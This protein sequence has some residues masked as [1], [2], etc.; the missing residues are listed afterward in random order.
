MFDLHDGQNLE[1]VVLGKILER[2]AMMKLTAML[3]HARNPGLE[4]WLQGPAVR[5]G[6]VLTVQK[7]FTNKLKMLNKTTNM[8][9]LNF[10]LNPTTTITQATKPIKLTMTLQ[11]LQDPVNTKP[12]KRNTRRTRPPS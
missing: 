3:A 5:G 4:S 6:A 7:L 8:I 12:M 1:K 9:A 2:M 11:K 10:A